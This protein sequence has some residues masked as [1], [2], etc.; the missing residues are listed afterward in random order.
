MKR[1]RHNL[2]LLALFTAAVFANLHAEDTRSLDQ[3]LAQ[4]FDYD[5]P[6]GT[7]SR[8]AAFARE[9][10]STGDIA[11]LAEILTQVARA[12]ALQGQLEEA[13]RT[14]DR[15]AALPT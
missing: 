12:Q 10:Q 8:L 11:S 13:A 4:D 5:D 14:L 3:R 9:T 1:G 15:A 2:F 7:E 6:K